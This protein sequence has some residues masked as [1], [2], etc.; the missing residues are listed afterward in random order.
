MTLSD[1]TRRA[2]VRAALAARQRQIEGK[3]E[4]R[5]AT[6]ELRVLRG[7]LR[8]A[9]LPAELDELVGKWCED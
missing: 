1:D 7:V 8:D 5:D 9:G 4:A 3:S 2:V 6:N